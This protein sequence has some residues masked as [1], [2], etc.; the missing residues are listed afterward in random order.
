MSSLALSHLL[1]LSLILTSSVT[2]SACSL[3]R[4]IQDS[5]T[6]VSETDGRPALVNLARI[7]ETVTG[8]GSLPEIDETLV[9]WT[10]AQGQAN[11]SIGHRAF[12][13]TPE[14][15]WWFGTGLPTERGRTVSMEPLIS[16]NR[17]FHMSWEMRIHALDLN[18]GEPLWRTSL[19]PEDEDTAFGGGLAYKDDTLYAT[20]GV[21]KVY[22]IDAASGNNRWTVD[23]ITPI[24]SGPLVTDSALIVTDILGKITALSFSGDVLWSL[25][26]PLNITTI[27]GANTPAAT[28][29][30]I[31]AIRPNGV[32]VAVLPTGQEAW[33]YDVGLQGTTGRL[34]DTIS[35]SRALLVID[36]NL[37]IASSW[38]D[39]TVAL[40]PATG[41]VRWQIPIGGAA[42]PFVTTDHIFLVTKDGVLRALERETGY[43]IWSTEL[44][45]LL[46]D[47][48]AKI[49][50]WFG[51]IAAGGKLLL[52][53]NGGEILFVDPTNGAISSRLDL[54]SPV[55][56]PLAL[57][58]GVLLVSTKDG[59][60]RAYK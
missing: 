1:R 53:S 10:Q 34:L 11:H 3:Y 19:V 57:A 27:L 16:G 38:A 44:D 43:Q 2:F 28:E 49:L 4:V 6:E 52:G 41:R 51:P 18:T 55:I 45:G 25:E 39:R 17:I 46:L 47:K 12:S 54:D 56:A 35:D 29:Q 40:D 50:N 42:T 36:D 14:Q 8:T 32:L 21:G 30:G 5:Q 33:R 13:E 20:S 24:R 23:L 60:I 37:L 7:V 48:R 15:I 9:D 31:Y 58:N 22:A 59:S 26:A